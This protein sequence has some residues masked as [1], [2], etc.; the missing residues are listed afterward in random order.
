MKTTTFPL[1]HS[2]KRS[3][4][5]LASLLIPLALAC[6]ALSPDAKAVC[7]N[8]CGT[9]RNT[10]LGDDALLSN[11]T[12]NDNTAI[13]YHALSSNNIGR[14]NTAAGVNAL[15]DNTSGDLNT[16]NGVRALERNTTGRENTAVGL[17]ALSNNTNGSDN[18]GL[19]FNA[20]AS[21]TTGS[22]NIDIGNLGVAGE[23][24]TIRIGDRTSTRT[25]IAGIRGV[26]VTGS[27]VVIGDGGQLGATPSSGR[28][29]D[30]VKPMDK[31]SEAIL[32][33]QPVTFHYKKELDS[34]GILQFG[35]VAEDVEKVNR[36]LVARDE[37][38]KPYSVRYEA[39]NAMLLNEFLKEHR[40][41]EKL[42]STVAQQRKDFE[43]VVDQLKAQIQKVSA[44]LE[45]S[46]L[47]P[48][49]VNNP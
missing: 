30:D 36:D 37:Q 12:G 46:K 5:P 39:V 40:K 43:A 21:L 42:E 32:S 35:L 6:F 14:F 38:G 9:I 16:A 4:Y 28:F 33:L 31:A 13:G 26:A 18:I 48:Q 23:S 15:N 11:T 49:V 19:G 29:K 44:Q 2:M 7:E 20:G 10:F 47:A 27:P 8:G 41:V 45:A 22:H 17:G 34:D 24:S 3:H 1:K 25:F